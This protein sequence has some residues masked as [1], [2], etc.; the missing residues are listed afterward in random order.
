MGS[1]LCFKYQRTVASDNTVRF[2]GHTLQL[3]PGLHRTSY[4]QAPSG[5]PGH[6][7]G[8]LDGRLVVQYQGQ[9]LASQEAPPSPVTLR[10][11]KADRTQVHW[12]PP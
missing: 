7:L 5:G 4:A 11:R 10:A 9:T 2:G 6:P 12:Q 3:L 8:G 1:I